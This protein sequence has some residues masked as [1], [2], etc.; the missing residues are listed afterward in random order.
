[1]S[2]KNTIFATE[3]SKIKLNYNKNKTKNYGR[4]I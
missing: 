2:Q 3:R 4:F 1:M